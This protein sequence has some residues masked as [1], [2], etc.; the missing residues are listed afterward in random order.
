MCVCVC[1]LLG[2]I[3]PAAS[4][5]VCGD[6]PAGAGKDG[7]GVAG[8]EIGAVGGTA[9]RLRPVRVPQRTS[10]SFAVNV[11]PPFYLHVSP[12]AGPANDT[13]MTRFLFQLLSLHMATFISFHYYMAVVMTVSWL[14]FRFLFHYP[15]AP[16]I[17]VCR[18]PV[19]CRHL[20]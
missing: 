11:I 10:L 9:G 8:S 1:G 2:V 19:Y 16:S 12:S 3:K 17:P 14:R 18:C 15:S 4:R 5:L 7:L 6:G 13:K 20:V